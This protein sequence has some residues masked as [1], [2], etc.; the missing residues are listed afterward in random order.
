MTEPT[1]G[2]HYRKGVELAEA[3]K[4]QE[5]L[6][7]IR[8]HLRSTP[9]DAEALNDAGAILHCL[10]RTDEAIDCLAKAWK[11]G[12]GSGQVAWNLVEAYLAG[13]MA[14]EAAALFDAMERLDLLNVDVLNRTAT[15]LL[16][17]DKKGEAIE[18]LLRSCRCWPD[19]EVLLP[20]LDV[21][22]NHRP[23]I[24][25]LSR[26]AD[27]DGPMA[28]ICDF[29]RQRFQIEVRSARQVDSVASPCDESDILWIDGGGEPAVRISQSDGLRK[30]IV[31]LR[32]G[33]VQGDWSRAMR[34]EKIDLVLLFGSSAVEQ[35][36]MQEVPDIRHRTRLTV[37]PYAANLDRYPLRRRE[38]GKN[39]ACMGRLDGEANP[40]LLIQCMQKLHYMD[41][42]Y[43]L[44]FS[45]EFA[46]PA[47][48]Q[49]VR[50]MVERLHLT[51]TVHFGPEPADWNTWLSD[52]H[53]VVACGSGEDQVE[54]VLT[55]LACGLKPVI[56]RFP[57]AENWFPTEYLFDIAEQFCECVLSPEYEPARY[58]RLVEDRYAAD[59]QLNRI[60]SIL[61]QF[62]KEIEPRDW[63]GTAPQTA[64]GE[65]PGV[66]SNPGMASRY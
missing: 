59:Q 16:E 39:L 41:P 32:H 11:L 23:K 31:S 51:E 38:R 15:M 60:N 22:R 47:M 61:L 35:A 5:G 18:V 55:A 27:G 36:L 44:F 29:I 40:A 49:Y 25:V 64:L 4:Y 66:A 56:H 63:S 62:E 58:R 43:K 26:E 2:S 52:K 33:D 6:N 57:G 10:G 53:F 20:M 19:Q 14:S 12:G 50:H 46:S 54:G 28:N 24:T 37:V 65:Q 8:E 30:T 13:G 34:W 48:A 42:E 1:A 7:C 9:H 3:G 17:Q 45:G 21:I